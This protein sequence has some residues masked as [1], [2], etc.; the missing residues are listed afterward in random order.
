[1]TPNTPGTGPQTILGFGPRLDSWEAWW[2]YN[3]DAYLGIKESVYRDA[4]V[5]SLDAPYLGRGQDDEPRAAAIPTDDQLASVVLPALIDA[6]EQNSS[7]AVR[8]ACIAALSQIGDLSNDD[9]EEQIETILKGS[10]KSSNRRTVEVSAAAMGLI[11]RRELIPTLSE[12]LADSKSGRKMCGTHSVPDRVRAFAAYG[13]AIAARREGS[14]D[15]QSY[16]QHKLMAALKDDEGRTPDLGV[17]CVTA[18]GILGEIAQDDLSDAGGE[19]TSLVGVNQARIQTLIEILEDKR[20]NRIVRAHV[21]RAIARQLPEDDG[22][23]RDAAVEAL[24][25]GVDARQREIRY[26]CIQALGMVGDC[27]DDAIDKKVRKTLLK[28][29]EDGDPFAKNFARIALGEVAGRSGGAASRAEKARSEIQSFLLKDLGGKRNLNRPWAGLALGVMAH[30]MRAEGAE[31]SPSVS[32]SLRMAFENAKNPEE[33]GAL[34]IAIGLAR[35]IG[36]S[37]M[38]I[39]RLEDSSDDAVKGWVAL[40]LGMVDA[41]HALPVLREELGESLRRPELMFNSSL[42][43]AL[44]GDKTVVTPLVANLAENKSAGVAAG[45]ARS[46]AFVGDRRA[47]APLIETLDRKGL[48]AT[49]RSYAAVALGLVGDRELVPWTQDLSGHLNYLALTETLHS[50]QLNGVLNIR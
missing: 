35:D 17:A 31:V 2:L 8:I 5:T 38:L 22:E 39:E 21:P 43:L 46:L 27:D 47:I 12:I 45:V 48:P 26:G 32:T 30:G 50:T 24:L 41:R 49:T 34:A 23:L 9:Q 40:S 36:A 44:L 29:A 6:W 1:M 13:L 37:D 42:A 28:Q 20:G 18:L 14:V 15:L 4:P 33:V 16:A 10:L 11:G 7:E 3:R 19:S 25:D